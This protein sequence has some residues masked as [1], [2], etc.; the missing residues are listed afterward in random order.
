MATDPLPRHLAFA[1]ES[2][3]LLPVGLI[4]DR[5]TLGA[6]SVG[7]PFLNPLAGTTNHIL[8]IGVD[9]HRFPR[10]HSMQGLNR[11][12]QF[13]LVVGDVT[14]RTPPLADYFIDRIL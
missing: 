3:Q 7:L 14:I 6:P 10:R 8:R 12:E 1:L 11:A 13:H 9:Q 5:L 2:V 4:L